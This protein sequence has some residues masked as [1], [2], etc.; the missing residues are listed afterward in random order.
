VYFLFELETFSS[1]LDYL[2]HEQLDFF[3]G[4]ET[5]AE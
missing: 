3:G 1:G 2:P 4:I 5:V